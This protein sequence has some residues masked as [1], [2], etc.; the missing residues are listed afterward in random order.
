M[1]GERDVKFV[2]TLG[3]ISSVPSPEF[4]YTVQTTS[5]YPTHGGSSIKSPDSVCL[6]RGKSFIEKATRTMRL[7]LQIVY[8]EILYHEE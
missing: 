4:V 7:F 6:N 2:Q 3:R 1:G 5:P 8:Y